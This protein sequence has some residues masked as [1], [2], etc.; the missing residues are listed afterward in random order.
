MVVLAFCLVYLSVIL[1]LNDGD[2]KAFVTIGSCYSSCNFHVDQGCPAGTKNGYDGQYAY[3][4]ARDPKGS[5]GCMDVPAYRYQRILLPMLGRVLS[6]GVEALIPVVFV[7]VNLIALVGSTAV[8]EY[9]LAD[10]GASRWCALAYGL[11]FGSVVGVRL[12]T[13]EPLAYG[14]AILAIGLSR[15]TPERTWLIALVSL[16][17][18]LAKET[19]G[20]FVAGFVLWYG[21]HRRWRDAALITLVVGAPFAL[22][23]IYLYK[24]IGAFGAGPGGGGKSSFEI[25][26][27]NGMWRIYTE[28]KSLA[29]FLLLGGLFIPSVVIP[30]AWGVW[31]TLR[32]LWKERH[33]LPETHLYTWLH[34]ANAGIIVF[35]PFSTY[36]EFL[37]IF[38]FTTGM[39]I[40]HL[41]YTALRFPGRRPLIY[42]TLWIVLLLFVVSG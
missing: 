34:L 13:V 28:T 14:L 5:I 6:F 3:Y 25:I 15:R 32:E 23:Q 11:F 16:A 36:R 39:V 30:S 9:L 20:L 8:V 37:G 26:P 21:T 42:S 17:A 40:T 19:T 2:V 31:T 4:I 18:M 1:A 38:R 24:W 12:S 7:V 29:V 10:Q 35:V 41:L 33:R 27:Y 22:W